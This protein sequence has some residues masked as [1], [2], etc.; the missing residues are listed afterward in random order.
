MTPEAPKYRTAYAL[1]M[2]LAE[3]K[4]MHVYWTNETRPEGQALVQGGTISAARCLSWSEWREL[5]VRC[6]LRIQCAQVTPTTLEWTPM[7]VHVARQHSRMPPSWQPAHSAIWE[8]ETSDLLGLLHDLGVDCYLD[9][10]N[11]KLR[12]ALTTDRSG[13]YAYL[14]DRAITQELD[15]ARFA[16]GERIRALR[17]P[18]KGMR[19]LRLVHEF[20][21]EHGAEG[22]ASFLTGLLG[23]GIRRKRA[24]YA[25][26]K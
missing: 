7:T 19:A 14:R 1:G 22:L 18:N 10:L 26:P 5:H 4:A 25:H 2:D 8:G 3:H 13:I 12:G 9:T 24:G 15:A 23:P 16:L 11:P 20:E 17:G 21:R 6:G